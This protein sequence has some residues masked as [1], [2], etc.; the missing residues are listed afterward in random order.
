MHRRILRRS[1]L[2]SV[3]NLIKCGSY[4]ERNINSI[5]GRCIVLRTS[6]I[7]LVFFS[8]FIFYV[9]VFSRILHR[10]EKFRSHILYGSCFFRPRER[11]RSGVGGVRG[12]KLRGN[13]FIEGAGSLLKRWVPDFSSIASSIFLH[14]SRDGST[15]KRPPDTLSCMHQPA[16]HVFC[17][18]DSRLQ[19]QVG[20]CAQ[21]NEG[22]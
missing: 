8:F 17:P 11:K 12:G 9:S 6:G 20:V 18:D 21:R 3:I 16:N 14:G 22:V 1:K 10:L 5:C 13:S 19:L 4:W 2:L 7:S 15:S